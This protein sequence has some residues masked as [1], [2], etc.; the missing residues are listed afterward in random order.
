MLHNVV[1]GRAR[2][3]TA[4]V[5]RAAREEIHPVSRCSSG[6][7][8]DGDENREHRGVCCNES[9][10]GC[11]RNVRLRSADDRVDSLCNWMQYESALYVI[12]P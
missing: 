5:T 6:V 3:L 4:R 1:V 11:S 8:K 9:S 7:S 10:A 2:Q 12:M